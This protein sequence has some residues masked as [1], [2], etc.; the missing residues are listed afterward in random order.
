MEKSEVLL[1]RLAKVRQLLPEYN[2]D[3]LIVMRHEKVNSVDTLYVSGFTGSTAILVVT[4][5]RAVFFTDS[6]YTQQARQETCNFDVIEFQKSDVLFSQLISQTL[7]NAKRVGV[8]EEEVTLR[9]YSLLKKYLSDVE[10][11]CLPPILTKIRMV[12]DEAEIEKIKRSIRATEN[13]LRQAFSAVRP[14]VSELDVAETFRSALPKGSKLA[15]DS[16]V[17]SGKRSILPHGKASRKLIEEG[18]VVQFDVGCMLDDYASDLS[19]VAICG[20]ASDEQ[21]RMHS[22]LVQAIDE[23]LQ[24]YGPGIKAVHSHKRA[25]EVLELCGYAD[26][27]FGHALGHGIG[28]EEHEDPHVTEKPAGVPDDVF[29]V[30]HVATIE[31]GI[32][33][34]GLGFGMRIELDVEII[35]DGHK[36]LD[37][38]PWRKIVETDKI[39]AKGRF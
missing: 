39:C 16:I 32:Y 27:K 11:V 20:K 8:M 25:L 3:A 1:Q 12:K 33:S 4:Q 22:A 17:A 15:F 10:I 5:E 14:G 36:I 26:S 28:L 19:R 23:A 13:A 30:G 7:G 38:L 29:E 35:P 9:F 6:R 34:A 24:F 18:D 2:V 37:R 31:P 21:K